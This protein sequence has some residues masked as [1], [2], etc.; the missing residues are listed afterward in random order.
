MF[1]PSMV[2]NTIEKNITNMSQIV[3]NIDNQYNSPDSPK[4]SK[5]KCAIM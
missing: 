1:R 2:E 4:K 3:T 5:P